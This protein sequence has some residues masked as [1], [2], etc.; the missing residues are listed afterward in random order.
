M[1]G[2]NRS[3]YTS[4]KYTGTEHEIGLKPKTSTPK[5][6]RS[7][8]CQSG[9]CTEGTGVNN[10]IQSAVLMITTLLYHHQR[11]FLQQTA[12]DTETQGQTLG[13]EWEILERSP[14]NG[15]LPSNLSFPSKLREPGGEK[16]DCKARGMRTQRKQGLLDRQIFCQSKVQPTPIF[17]STRYISAKVLRC[18]NMYVFTSA[19]KKCDQSRKCRESLPEIFERT[20]INVSIKYESPSLQSSHW[21]GLM[22]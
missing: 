19:K 1:K 14:L 9:E 16:K 11:S 10:R 21:S 5:F 22:A 2:H 6:N 7:P 17:I 4:D 12:I 15:R 18:V 13:R 3:L 8:T 20:V